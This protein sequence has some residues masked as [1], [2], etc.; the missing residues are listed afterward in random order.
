METVTDTTA[1]A[2][3]VQ[4]PLNTA[5]SIASLGAFTESA[6]GNNPSIQVVKV[7]FAEGGITAIATDRFIA[8]MGSYSYEY[9]SYGTVYLDAAAIKF[10]SGLKNSAY[11]EF[12]YYGDQLTVTD[13]NSSVSCKM[14]VGKYPAVDEMIRDHQAAEHVTPQRFRV[15]LIAKL[16]KVL[17]PRDGKK[18]EQWTFTQGVLANGSS[19]PGPMLATAENFRAIIQPNLV[20]N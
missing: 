6:R 20:A 1:T 8:I 11:V 19:K 15:E 3:S 16:A 10:I 2:L 17:S 4:V 5:R 7:V 9:D 18:V 13:G 14:Y 12:T